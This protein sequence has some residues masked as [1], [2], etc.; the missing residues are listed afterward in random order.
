MS[1]DKNVYASSRRHFKHCILNE[2]FPKNLIMAVH[3]S[4]EMNVTEDQLLSVPYALSK[5]EERERSVLLLRYKEGCTL[6]EIGSRMGVGGTRIQ[7]IE[8]RALR[9][10]R[11]PRIHQMI[12][13]GLDEYINRMKNREREEGYKSGYAKGYEKG[14]ADSND[15]TVTP[16]KSIRIADLPVESLC[17]GVRLANALH[18]AGYHHLS[19]LLALSEKQVKHNPHVNTA[20]RKQIA[21]G[22]MRYGL[23]DTSWDEYL[24]FE[25]KYG[26]KKETKE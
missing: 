18:E 21:S 22:L 19:D 25:Q 9:D 23:K 8:S 7:Q 20:Q 10:L 6:D 17:I 5:L 13:Y 16:G 12:H 26:P 15:G 14:L 24:T 11:H 3:E 4:L 2:P 1:E